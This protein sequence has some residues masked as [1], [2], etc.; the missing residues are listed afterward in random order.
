M[1]NIKSDIE[2]ILNDDIS[3]I[4]EMS[5]PLKFVRNKISE[6]SEEF[7]YHIIKFLIWGDLST[8]W[9]KTIWSSCQVAQKYVLS[10]THKFPTKEQIKY[11]L[12]DETLQ[13]FN[14]LPHMITITIEENIHKLDNPYPQPRDYNY[15]I[16]LNNFNKFIDSICNELSTQNL[17]FQKTCELCNT[18]LIP[19]Q[20][21]EKQQI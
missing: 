19:E 6:Q 20:K 5:R 3:F 10:T 2:Q 14:G 7:I 21:E 11:W 8:D 13:A 4:N 18:Y 16:L 12:V 15:S 17:T 1:T 9:Y